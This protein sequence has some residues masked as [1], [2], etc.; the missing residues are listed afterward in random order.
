MR[1]MNV[2]TFKQT[3]IHN[4]IPPYVILSHRWGRQELSYQDYLRTPE[5]VF[6][7]LPT[8]SG[9][10]EN[11]G[12]P[13]IAHACA[14]AKNAGIEWIWIDTCCI[15]KTSSAE[16]SRSINSM[17]SW[18]EEAKV[19]FAYLADVHSR[20]K[21][22]AAVDDEILN[23]EWFRRG[24]TLQ[25][26]LAPREMIFYDADWQLL[27]SRSRLTAIIVEAAKISPEHLRNFRSA[28]IAQKMS[29]MADRSTTEVED[30][31]YCM[32]GLFDATMDLRP[33]EGRKAFLRLQEVIIG[34]SPDESIFA[35]TSHKYETSGLLAPWIDCFRHSGNVFLRPDKITYFRGSYQMASGGLNFPGPAYLVGYLELGDA[36]A[37]RIASKKI[38]MPTQCW[39]LQNGEPRAIVLYMS[40]EGGYWKRIRCG[41]WGTASK[42]KMKSKWQWSGPAL[43]INIH[44][45]QRETL[46]EP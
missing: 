1:L 38:E 5:A 27:G 8:A 36:I 40:K 21:S 24:W 45:P 32:L 42:V 25:E 28:S 34:G 13:K 11:L 44:V 35:W 7:E 39:T 18:Y 14:Q 41:E 2:R 46:K 10:N 17:F 23:S 33:G 22:K 29:W 3:E 26:M 4:S 20:G 15:D 6:K 19:C 16:L 9:T 30:T 43:M 37:R 12:V 31:A